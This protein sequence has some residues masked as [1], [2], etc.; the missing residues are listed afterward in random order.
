MTRTTVA[1][2][3]AKESMPRRGTRRVRLDTQKIVAAGLEVAAESASGTFSPKL[4]GDK[5][6]ADPSAVY[7]HFASKRHLMEALLDAVHLRTLEQVTAPREAWRERIAQLASATLIEYCRHPS[8]AAEAMT[9]TT[10][11]PGEF[12][13]VE[14]LL[15]ALHTCGLPDDGVVTHYALISAYMLSMA[16]GIARSRT[17]LGELRPEEPEDDGP[18]LDGPILADPRSYPQT[19][20]LTLQL[21]ELRDREIYLQGVNVLLDAAER[22]A[23]AQA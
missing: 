15:D 11:G 8:I 21:A 9:L 7:R 3:V 10:H 14:L 23:R 6:G 13:A 4:L 20:R 5:L 19:A 17:D 12:G 1:E 22:E 2:P 18:W 16:S